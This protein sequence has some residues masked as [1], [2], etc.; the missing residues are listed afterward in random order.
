ML[1]LGDN[2][3]P[4]PLLGLR[5]FIALCL[6]LGTVGCPPQPDE[7]IAFQSTRYMYTRLQLDK[8][9]QK[10]TPYVVGTRILLSLLF[11]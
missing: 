3:E 6:D 7:A 8:Y 10:A 4:L 2:R 5:P 9:R 1:Q 11:N